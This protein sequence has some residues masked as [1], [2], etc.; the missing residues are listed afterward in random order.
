MGLE[1]CNFEQVREFVTLAWGREDMMGTG[2]L[3]LDLW[4]AVRWEEVQ[5]KC[6]TPEG[7]WRGGNF[8]EAGLD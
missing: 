6:E 4:K 5:P 7:V 8:K 3:S 1:S 2:L